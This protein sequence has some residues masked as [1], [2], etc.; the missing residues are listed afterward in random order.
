MRREPQ[1]KMSEG[2]RISFNV[3]LLVYIVY[4]HLMEFAFKNGSRNA[5]H[6]WTCI[7]LLR[8][9]FCDASGFCDA[10][11]LQIVMPSKVIKETSE[12]RLS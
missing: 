10:F 4:V 12:I 1:G 11:T 8:T 6:D 3:K 5:F 7:S 9:D 2:N